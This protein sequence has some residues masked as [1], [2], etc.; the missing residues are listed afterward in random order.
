MSDDLHGDFDALSRKLAL[1]RSE[2]ESA[3]FR[4]TAACQEVKRLEREQYQIW[5]KMLDRSIT[6][7]L[8]EAQKTL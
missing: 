7:G 5:S 3:Y 8:P 4:W 1:A 6:K 2:R